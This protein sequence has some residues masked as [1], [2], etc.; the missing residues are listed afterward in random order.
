MEELVTYVEKSPRLN[1]CTRWKQEDMLNSLPPL[2]RDAL[3]PTA[4]KQCYTKHDINSCL[5]KVQPVGYNE[6]KVCHTTVIPTSISGE[7][8]RIAVW[9]QCH[10]KYDFNSCLCKVQ[11]VGYREKKL[12]EKQMD[13]S[14]K[15][16]TPFKNLIEFGYCKCGNFRMGKFSCFFSSLRKLPPRE[17]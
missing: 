16:C 5:S 4:W 11:P 13:T 14:T 1:K 12:V 17:N 9:K 7:S 15:M 10:A 3:R 2:V 6:K 8:L